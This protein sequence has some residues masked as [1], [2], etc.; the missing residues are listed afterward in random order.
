MCTE[1]TQDNIK[2]NA[3]F[4]KRGDS[5]CV[6]FYSSRPLKT[7]RSHGVMYE[8]YQQMLSKGTPKVSALVAIAS[9]LLRIIF[10]LVKNDTLY[11]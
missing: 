10:A 8:R 9:R 6:N 3:I 11:R 5:C 7:V 1:N 4:R 2:V